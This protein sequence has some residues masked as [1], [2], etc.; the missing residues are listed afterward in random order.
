MKRILAI[1][2]GIALIGGITAV[3]LSQGDADGKN[4]ENGNGTATTTVRGVIGSEKAAFFSDPDVKKAL[5]DEGLSVR[6]DTSGSWAMED[7]DLKGYDFAFPS[8]KEPADELA[9]KL[10]V[11]DAPARPFYSPLVVATHRATAGV[12]AANGL[13]TLSGKGVGTLRMDAYLKAAKADRLWQ[14]L[15]GASGHAELTGT[16]S[17]TTTDPRT[18]NSGALYLAA[19]SYVDNG[20]QVVSD[21]AGV[22]RTAPLLRKLTA[23]QGSQQSS[24]EQ[25]FTD[26]VSGV[27]NPLVLAYESQVAAQLIQRDAPD[28]LVVLYPDTEVTSDHNLVP[29]TAAGKKLGALL[30]DDPGLRKLEARFGFRPRGGTEFADATAGHKDHINQSLSGVKQAPAPRADMLRDMARRAAGGTS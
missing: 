6:V 9:A 28:D 12:L 11:Q 8:S 19:A 25:P 18:S 16:L 15:K 5:A 13:A 29:L 24:S 3:L 17:I 1:V 22:E 14:D 23:V 27:G 4:G 20:G 26:F 7:R 2:F 10:H 30:S 21:E